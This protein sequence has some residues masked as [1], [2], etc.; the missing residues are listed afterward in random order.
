MDIRNLKDLEKVLKQK[1]QEVM[2]DDVFEKVLQLGIKSAADE[3]YEAYTP[4]QYKRT[5]E[6][7]ESF[8]YKPIENGIEFYNDRSDRGRNVAEI[9]EKGHWGSEGYEFPSFYPDGS[10][11]EYMYPRPFMANTKD[12]LENGEFKKALKD[13]LNKRGIRAE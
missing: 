3:V 1:V 9:V 5:Y 4:T 7:L 6:L 11:K 8:K 10:P 13:G 12:G 2:E